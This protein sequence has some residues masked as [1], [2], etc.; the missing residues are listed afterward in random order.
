MNRPEWKS[1]QLFDKQSWTSHYN[2]KLNKCLVNVRRIQLFKDK[3]E[4]FE[5]NHVYDAIEG[6]IIG[7]K[8]LTKKPI[9]AEPKV[10]GIVLLQGERLIRDPAEAATVLAWFDSLME[11]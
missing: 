4:V 5:M 2:N 11:D 1:S 9:G 10:V 7:G 8:L 3:D 6:R